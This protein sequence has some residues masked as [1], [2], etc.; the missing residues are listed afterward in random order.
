MPEPMRISEAV[1]HED[2]FEAVREGRATDE[3]YRTVTDVAEALLAYVEPL[4]RRARHYSDALWNLRQAGLA[5]R[6]GEVIGVVN[7]PK[8]VQAPPIP[9]PGG[10]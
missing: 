2:A 3:Q 6:Q 1:A 8:P 10:E 4:R 5:D 9:E 7:T